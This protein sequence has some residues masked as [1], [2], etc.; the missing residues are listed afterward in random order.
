MG[1]FDE[2]TNA[3]VLVQNV[4]GSDATNVIVSL[5]PSD[6]DKVLPESSDSVN[7]LPVGYQVMFLLTA[8]TAF[9]KDTSI[10]VIVTND[11]MVTAID[12]KPSCE[13]LSLDEQA[14]INEYIESIV[15]TVESVIE[16]GGK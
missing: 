16:S 10:E 14:R 2:T 12:T 8:D 11:Q 1:F 5:N 6:L 7:Y 13:D 15:V 9:G 4:G 3:W